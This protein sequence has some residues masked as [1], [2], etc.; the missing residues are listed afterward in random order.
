LEDWGWPCMFLVRAPNH[1]DDTYQFLNL[2]TKH[3]IVSRD[4][5]WLGIVMVIR[6]VL[7]QIPLMLFLLMMTV[8]MMMTLLQIQEWQTGQRW[9]WGEW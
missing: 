2:A 1:A 8:T 4:V 5:L 3:A 7:Q 9:R 6:K